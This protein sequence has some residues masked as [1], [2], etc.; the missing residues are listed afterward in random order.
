MMNQASFFE[1]L[2]QFLIQIFYLVIG[3]LQFQIH[4]FERISGL[5]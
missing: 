5:L 1:L 2:F 3:F 4:R